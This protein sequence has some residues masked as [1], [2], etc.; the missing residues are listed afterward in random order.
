MAKESTTTVAADALVKLSMAALVVVFGTCATSC[1]SNTAL[2]SLGQVAKIGQFQLIVTGHKK[3]RASTAT[4]DVAG[5]F[6]K[7]LCKLNNAPWFNWV[8]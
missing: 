2:A 3:A 1:N 4:F 6:A 7:P 8:T 5:G